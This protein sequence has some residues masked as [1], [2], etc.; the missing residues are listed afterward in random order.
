MN[1]MLFK[2]TVGESFGTLSELQNRDV[3][4]R[5]IIINDLRMLLNEIDEFKLEC[6]EFSH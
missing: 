2:L 5:Y 4:T 6:Y 3:T 1:V